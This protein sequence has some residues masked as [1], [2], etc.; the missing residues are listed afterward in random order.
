VYLPDV[1][2]PA[3]PEL[4]DTLETE[5]TYAFG[6]CSLVNGLEGSYLSRAGTVI[7]D[8]VNLLFTDTP[9][10]FAANLETLSK[11]VDTLRSAVMDA[12]E[13][14]EILIVVYPVFHCE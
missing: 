10:T 6:G 5:F 4:R 9:F 12:L 2:H 11:Y 13:E 14:E 8:R 7:R 1:R 3:Y